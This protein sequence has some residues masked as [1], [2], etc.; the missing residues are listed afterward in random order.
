MK[1]MIVN[2]SM[3][4]LPALIMPT[5][6]AEKEEGKSDPASRVQAGVTF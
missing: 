6:A 2:A 5:D 4:P 3:L 1:D